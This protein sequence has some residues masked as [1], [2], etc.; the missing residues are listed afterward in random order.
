MGEGE[1]VKNLMLV[2][3]LHVQIEFISYMYMAFFQLSQLH[4]LLSFIMQSRLYKIKGLWLVND[5]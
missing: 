1:G 5:I 2:V 3:S 4:V